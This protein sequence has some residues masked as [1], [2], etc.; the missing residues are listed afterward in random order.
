MNDSPG[1]IRESAK[2]GPSF[3]KAR[4]PEVSDSSL[5]ECLNFGFITDIASIEV[6]TGPLS[7]QLEYMT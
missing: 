7:C 2:P 1:Q 6:V 3:D 5:H 4:S